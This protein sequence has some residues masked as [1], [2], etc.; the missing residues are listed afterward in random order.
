MDYKRFFS[1][2]SWFRWK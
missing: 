2:I 1:T